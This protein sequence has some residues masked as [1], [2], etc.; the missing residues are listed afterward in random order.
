MIRYIGK[1]L[2]WMIPVML[3]IAILIFSIMYICPGDPAQS[4]LGPSA[5]AVELAA[6]REELGLNDPYIVRLGRYLYQT[7]IR[8]DLGDSYKYGTSVF[9]GLMERMRYTLVIALLCMALQVFVGTPLGI[10]AATHHNGVA[11]RICM[12]LALVGVSIPAFWLALM[13]VLIFA[14]NLN[15]LPTSGVDNG[16]FSF[17]MPCIANSFAGI[18]SQARHTRSSMLEVIRSDYI[19]TAKAKGLSPR[20]VLLRHALPNALIPIITIIGNGYFDLAYMSRETR[21]L[22]TR[23]FPS[24]SGIDFPRD[25]PVQEVTD[26]DVIPLRG[27]DLRVFFI[28][29]HAVG[30]LAFL[31]ERARILF[32]GDEFMAHGKA[33][34]GSVAHWAQMLEKLMPYRD[35]FDHLCAGAWP[36]MDASIVYNQ[37][38]CARHILAGNEGDRAQP[39][40][41]PGEERVDAE[42]RRIWKRRIPHPGDGPADINRDIEYKRVM[43]F[44]GTSITYDVRHIDD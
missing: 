27:R 7:F 21:E 28:P 39:G 20:T 43:R 23:P 22:A 17:I 9:E 26:G 11:D 35:R 36:M 41:F 16:L 12:L 5:T 19:V 44:A 4:M 14:V 37:L 32:S 15:W 31:D 33:L 3:G 34:H 8:F 10:A 29:D 18:A 25:Y 24:F 13:L 40:R 6:K 38:A 2:L 30:S 1:R 42:G